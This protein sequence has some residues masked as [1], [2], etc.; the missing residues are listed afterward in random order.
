MPLEGT[1]RV[2]CNF[3]HKLFYK[4]R[5]CFNENLKL[6]LNSYCSKL[7]FYSYR[8]TGREIICEND[9]CKNKFYRALNDILTH[10]YCSQ[11]CATIVNNKKYPKRF[12]LKRL[13]KECGEE[14]KSRYSRYCSSSCGYKHRKK[15]GLK[16]T[17]QQVIDLIQKFSSENNRVP[18][19]REMP[20]I[21]GR[22]HH[23]FGS[24]N[25]AVTVAGLTP[26]RSHENRMYKRTRTKAKDGHI[27]DSI[28]EAIIDNWL[29]ENKISHERNAHYPNSKHL[30]DWSIKDNVFIEYF[31]L[32]KDSP[33][34][35]RSVKEK[36][37][38]CKKHGIKLIAIYPKDLYPKMCLGEK[39]K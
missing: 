37:R 10:N 12:P 17:H 16:Y 4:E 29:A 18:A 21:M 30:A 22:A 5:R 36:T 35:D 3:C 25:N 24:W 23:M 7:C 9:L 14:F 38:L 27:C 31:G 11:T 13:C 2:K 8:K 34:Y 19:K 1:V 20:E 39:L 26:N 33:R 32:A 15:H 28:S 6:G